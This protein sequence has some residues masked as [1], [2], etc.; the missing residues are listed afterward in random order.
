M[1][2]RSS[3]FVLGLVLIAAVGIPH[4][5]SAQIK[6]ADDPVLS[7]LEWRSIG[8]YR[9]GRSV[10]VSGVA[11]DPK[12]F[13]MGTTGGGV[14][15]TR[16]EGVTWACVSDGFFKLG[17]VGSIAV[18][19]SNSKV[20]YVGMGEHAIRGNVTPGDGVYRS[21]D[22]GDS[23][24]HM[25]LAETQFIGR[26][27]V[28]P[29]DPDTVWVAALGP[30]FGKSKDRGIYKSK[31][32]G[33]SWKKTL[34]V[35]DQA[36][37]IELAIDPANPDVMFAGTWEMWRRPWELVS[38]GPG[39]GLW[40]SRDGGEKWENISGR[41]GLPTGLWG[42]VGVSVS[43]AD[44][45]RIYAMI[46]A[47]KGGLYLSNDGGKTWEL[48]N[49]SSGPRQRPWYYTR[50]FADPK[51]KD[52]VYILNVQYYKSTDAGKTLRAGV[53]QHS[54]HH[55]LWIDS[56]D[57]KRLVIGTDG[58]A[59][60]SVNGGG[61]W[62]AQ[63]YPTGQFYHVSVDN[64][65]PYNVLGAQQ[66][67][68]TVR[69]PSR[70]RG[71]GITGEDWTSTAG[72]ESGYVV[73]K[74]DRPEIV[75][76][77]SY[78]G[79]LSWRNHL[80]ETSRAVDPW[81]DNPLGRGAVEAV[82]RFQWTFPIVF[83]PHDPNTIYVGSQ[84]VLRSRDMGG[85]WE[86]IS[87]DLT[88]NDSK[89]MQPS[90]GPISKDNTSVE[91]HCT[92]FTIAECQA[93][94]GVIWAGSDDGLIHLT[95]DNGATW[96]NVTPKGM[97]N[98]ATVSLIEASPHSAGRAIAAVNN[99]RQN[100]F[101]PYVFV[102]DDY[103]KTWTALTA[104]I[105]DDVWVRAVR[106]DLLLK[107]LL[108][109]GTEAGVYVSAFGAPWKKLGG[110]PE[111]PV[112]DLVLKNHDLI[113][114]THGRGFYILDS[115]N[116]IRGTVQ[117]ADLADVVLYPAFGN[118]ARFGPVGNG[119][120]GKNPAGSG[121][122]VE[123]FAKNELKDVVVTMRDK[124]GFGVAQAKIGSAKPGLNV[125]YLM[126]TYPGMQT[127]TGLLM[128][129]G[130]TG[131]LKAPP[132]EYVL[133]LE[134]GSTKLETVAVWSNNPGSTA[135]DAD[136]VAKYELSRKVAD[137]ATECNMM[138]MKTRGYRA[139]IAEAMK[140]SKELEDKGAYAIRI[141]Q[142]IEDSLHQGK[143]GAGQ[144][145]LNFPMQLNNRFAALLGNIQSGDYG[146]TK[147]SF[148]VYDSLMP[149]LQAERDRMKEFETK[150]LPDL[151]KALVAAGKP[152]LAPKFEELRPARG[153]IST[154]ATGE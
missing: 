128:W 6:S 7:K 67:N 131:T 123:F 37:A 140:G 8:P 111:A 130:Y 132:G 58:G 122:R 70:T 13:F 98:G 43:G 86:R 136:M 117:S 121:L 84:H 88:T 65:F 74:P 94:K 152:E 33:K 75:F 77:G 144:D 54:D 146:A 20:V 80:L 90:G 35:N 109:A 145:F 28:H 10:A 31:D 60:V 78:G 64:S 23:W 49:G 93:E 29:K 32:G 63:D 116:P 27:I 103:G 141:L 138:V 71:A 126:P 97:P 15:R 81:P 24:R 66:D 115:V 102:T 143:A 50:V 11:D 3:P 41:P 59:S 1:V 107:G 16:D 22:G 44:P 149:L 62:S 100:D 150:M 5:A 135:S 21:D 26:V 82:E 55:D 153:G 104:G 68:S 9:G 34:F 38:G 18:A 47:E 45:N 96:K 87:P 89:K 108:Y 25:G 137:A 52:T 101:R 91:V 46:E 113:V 83:S 2:R 95:I 105:P 120:V 134:S 40:T 154:G 106:E 110:L 12:T 4:S 39:S 79:D 17:S 139:A 151:N 56:N 57:N 85:S 30:V 42:K 69:I 72:G 73:A 147:Q 124:S 112:H 99:Y 125:A 129:S 148:A 142:S 14:W 51:E 61:A 36:G 19:R 127:F 92:V 76:G 118:P 53:A 114:A 133:Q 119:D 48:S